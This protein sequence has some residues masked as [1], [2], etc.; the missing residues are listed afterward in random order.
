MLLDDEK[1]TKRFDVL[2][3]VAEALK[4]A[5]ITQQ[6][7][8]L[9]ASPY[10][11]LEEVPSA[12]S[13]TPL[14]AR[15]ANRP[16][17]NPTVSRRKSSVLSETDVFSPRKLQ[18]KAPLLY[19]TDAGCIDRP[20]QLPR[21]LVDSDLDTLRHIGDLLEAAAVQLQESVDAKL[22]DFYTH[23]SMKANAATAC[24]VQVT[25]E[26][27]DSAFT[28][29]PFSKIDVLKS[30]AHTSVHAEAVCPPSKFALHGRFAP[31]PTVAAAAAQQPSEV[32]AVT[33]GV[34]SAG[35]NASE[36]SSLRMRAAFISE[37]QGGFPP[38]TVSPHLLSI[39]NSVSN[40]TLDQSNR[41]DSTTFNSTGN[42]FRHYLTHSCGRANNHTSNT[43]ALSHNAPMARRMEEERAAVAEL[44]SF[45]FLLLEAAMRQ[46][47]ATAAAIYMDDATLHAN[48]NGSDHSS[49][50]ATSLFGGSRN[51]LRLTGASANADN[52]AAGSRAQFLHCVAHVRGHFPHTISYA[53]TNVLTTVAQTG[54]AVN[55]NYSESS[56]VL[57][58]N[59]FNVP[60][61][62]A[63]TAADMGGA[64]SRDSTSSST[65]SKNG[66]AAAPSNPAL[67]LNMYNGIVVPIKDVGCLVIA[68]KAKKPS[69]VA[70]TVPPRFSVF[71]EHVAW[72]SALISEAVLQRYHRELL[73][74]ATGW[75]PPC[76]TTLRPFIHTMNTPTTLHPPS[77]SGTAD[78][79]GSQRNNTGSLGERRRMEGRLGAH[80]RLPTKKNAEVLSDPGSLF[81]ALKKDETAALVFSP[82]TD[83]YTKR[84]T[85]VRTEDRQVGKAL[86]PELRTSSSTTLPAA[87]KVVAAVA[88]SGCSASAS[89]TGL[90]GELNDEDLF[91][92][93]AQYITNLES[94]WRKTIADSNTMHTM[95]DNCNKEIQQ[96]RD[97]IVHLESHIRELNAH[98]VQ[99]ERRNNSSRFRSTSIA[100]S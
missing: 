15:V 30:R 28:A 48:A 99:L 63:S 75:A 47:D 81:E 95:V 67:D 97:E 69:S 19:N 58:Q 64:S 93:A 49:L 77:S 80:R 24:G 9:P 84:L 42:G 62:E 41:D 6:R 86:P 37:T 100:H 79:S 29:P 98:V 45:F 91:L 7:Q 55:L 1:I 96:R 3:R 35:N 53:L 14:H 5:T 57:R 78:G 73:L 74:R 88:R 76:A 22:V 13:R 26:T 90:S 59:G 33:S 85:I 92:A 82:Q 70:G 12:D 65:K 16:S 4:Q 8:P 43:Y 51:A 87:Q 20:V 10:M 21:V 11:F 50:R 60:P 2:F 72:S 54:I 27:I 25:A 89:P 46:T 36:G 71:D 56:A 18:K 44:Q 40:S 17:S 66:T 23:L 32:K 61:S 34:P 39:G 94:L 68:N 31:L 83:L 52:A 38:S